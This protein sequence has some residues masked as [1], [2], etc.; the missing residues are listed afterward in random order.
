MP[1]SREEVAQF[2]MN[3]AQSDAPPIQVLVRLDF[4]LC[5]FNEPSPASFSFIYDHLQTDN[6]TNFTRN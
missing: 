4:N 2:L 5:F 6:N 1:I 3:M